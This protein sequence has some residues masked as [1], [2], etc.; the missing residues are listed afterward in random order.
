[1]AR[2]RAGYLYCLTGDCQTKGLRAS[3]PA[4]AVVEQ[5]KSNPVVVRLEDVIAHPEHFK[6]PKC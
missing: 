4:Y 5:H 3:R 2:V 6:R 1:M